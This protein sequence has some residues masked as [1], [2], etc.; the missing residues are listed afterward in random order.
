MPRSNSPQD[1]D[2]TLVV[3]RGFHCGGV[4][5]HPPHWTTT[6]TYSLPAENV[7]KKICPQRTSTDSPAG[8]VNRKPFAASEMT[9]GCVAYTVTGVSGLQF[10]PDFKAS[11]TRFTPQGD[12][13]QGPEPSHSPGVAYDVV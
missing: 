6:E 5:A 12:S 1:D 4:T 10:A 9:N 11:P 8:V 3:R 13:T 7:T 2:V